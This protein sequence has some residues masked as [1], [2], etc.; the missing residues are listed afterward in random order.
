MRTGFAITIL[1]VSC[2]CTRAAV[3]LN[4]AAADL[5]TSSGDLMP[6]GGLVL[7]VASTT[8]VSFGA[9]RA[10]YFVSGDDLILQA[11]GLQREGVFQGAPN[12][13]LDLGQANPSFPNL[14]QGDPLRLYWFPTLTLSAYNP[15]AT[16]G[17][18]PGE[19]PYGFYWDPAT[20]PA[21]PQNGSAS[22]VIPADGSTVTLNFFT[23]PF[24]AYDTEVGWANFTVAPVPE[25]SNVIFGGLALGLVAFR[26]VPRLRRKFATR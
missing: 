12:L 20:T 10:D 24:G 23:Q 25:A 21:P 3:T 22:W 9:P 16:G 8:D 26:L 5:R 17:G 14:T 7:L 19:V 11:W 4:I 6:V 15:L 18:S 1:A 13:T 2:L